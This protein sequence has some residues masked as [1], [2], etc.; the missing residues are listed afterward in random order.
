MV[1]MAGVDGRPSTPFWGGGGGEMFETKQ[2][3]LQRK[4]A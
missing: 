3:G 2:K 4:R 1:S